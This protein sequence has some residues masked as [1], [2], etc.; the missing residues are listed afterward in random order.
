MS[1][2][3][4]AS[5]G[6]EEI[7]RFY[8][9]EFRIDGARKLKPLEVEEAVYPYMGPGRTPD[10]VE[11]ARQALEKAYHDKGWQAASVGIPQQDPSRG[12]IH[13]VVLE[14]KVGRLRVNGAKWFL[15]SRIKQEVPSVAEGGVPDLNP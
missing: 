9:R 2:V 7:Q 4:A 12:V 6:A 5:T 15:P 14:G 13:L 11:R 10:D 1:A 3:A 8:I